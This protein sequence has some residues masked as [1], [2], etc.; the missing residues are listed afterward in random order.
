MYSEAFTSQT[1]LVKVWETFLWFRFIMGR[2][3]GAWMLVVSSVL[4]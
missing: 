4:L 3:M 2:Y 1:F